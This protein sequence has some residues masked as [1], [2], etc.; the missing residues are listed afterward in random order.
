MKSLLFVLIT[1]VTLIGLGFAYNTE[2]RNLESEFTRTST[3]WNYA[4]E[5]LEQAI[6]DELILRYDHKDAVCNRTLFKLKKLVEQDKSNPDL[7]QKAYDN[8][9]DLPEWLEE[10]MVLVEL[11]KLLPNFEPE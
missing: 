5:R 7:I 10:R 6:Q 11:S 8:C 3:E 1:S 9:E 2:G 4:V